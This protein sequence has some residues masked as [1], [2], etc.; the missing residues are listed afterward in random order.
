MVDRTKNTRDFIR[1]L[2]S[3]R[4]ATLSSEKAQYICQKNN[5]TFIEILQPFS[6]LNLEGMI[7]TK[8]SLLKRSNIN[9]K[10][11]YLHIYIY[12]LYNN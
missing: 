3:P 6:R 4:T 7:Y 8:N 2:F 11:I 1:E 12:I 9:K 5:L 10:I